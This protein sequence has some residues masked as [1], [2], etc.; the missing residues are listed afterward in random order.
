MSSLGGFF[1][2]LR[3]VL[4][5]G[6]LK[7]V[8]RKVLDD[9]CFGL[10]GQMAYFVL[11]S[12]FPLLMF[13]VALTGIVVD[14]PASAIEGLAESMKGVLPPDAVGLLEDYIDRT[15]RGAGVGVL[16]AGALAGLWSGSGASYALIQASNR[17]YGV[18]ETRPLWKVSGI[19]VLMVVGF[20]LLIVALALVI[21]SPHAGGYVQR[22]YG[23]PDDFLA[24]WGRLRWVVAFV[25]VMLVHDVLYYL[26][27]DADLPFEWITPGGLTATVLV[28]VSS[29]ALSFYAGS[30]GRYD[31]LYGPIAAVIVLVLWLYVGSLMVL[32]GTEMNAV[33]ARMAAERKGVEHVRA[34]P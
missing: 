3:S 17:A 27:P 29:V 28:L 10:A 2:D 8:G 25:A 30:F 20:T 7:R 26:A 21:L 16:L 24:L 32:I 15:L 13:I 33:L 23:L 1:S 34:D 9:D 22:L 5:F 4:G 12:L 18:R 14:D 19:C 31:Q 6:A 11:L